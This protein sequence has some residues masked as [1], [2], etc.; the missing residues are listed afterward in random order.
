MVS[1]PTSVAI[2]LR[3]RLSNDFG[4]ATM[5]ATA[6]SRV[7]PERQNNISS[8]RN[9]FPAHSGLAFISDAPWQWSRTIITLAHATN[10]KKKI[11]K[12]I[13]LDFALLLH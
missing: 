3:Q 8:E 13:R 1:P 6:T 9:G 11:V 2:S 7:S 10:S 5:R 4:S 12:A